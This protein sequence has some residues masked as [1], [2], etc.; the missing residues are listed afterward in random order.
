VKPKLVPPC[1]MY[2]EKDALLASITD[3]PAATARE[4]VLA[5]PSPQWDSHPV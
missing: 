5:M 3:S 2:S 1:A 4:E